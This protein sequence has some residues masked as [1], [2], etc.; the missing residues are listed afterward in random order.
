VVAGRCGSGSGC[1][2][3]CGVAGRDSVVY[4]VVAGCDVAGCVVLIAANPD[5]LAKGAAGRAAVLC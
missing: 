1:G 5:V 3:C 2:S 4:G